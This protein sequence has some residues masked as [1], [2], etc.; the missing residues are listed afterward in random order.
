MPR[1][2]RPKARSWS[3]GSISV[4]SQVAPASGVKSFTTGRKVDPTFGIFLLQL[5]VQRAVLEQ[6]LADFFGQQFHLRLL[7]LVTAQIR[8]LSAWRTARASARAHPK[9]RNGVKEPAGLRSWERRPC[10]LCCSWK[11]QMRGAGRTNMGWG[12]RR[13]P[14][15]EGAATLRTAPG[16]QARNEGL[17]VRRPLS[18]A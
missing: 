9:G 16:C 18:S 6:P 1:S 4:S 15:P 5:A 2:Q 14:Q 7:R 12:H 17:R 8:G 10:D 13:S 11:G 3:S